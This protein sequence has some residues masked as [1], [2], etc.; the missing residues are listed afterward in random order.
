MAP[1]SAVAAPARAR[2]SGDSEAVPPPV[3]SRLGESAWPRRAGARPC[4]TPGLET[5][6]GA[7]TPL[8]R[9]FCPPAPL[10]ALAGAGQ[11]GSVP[12]GRILGAAQRAQP[13]PSRRAAA[14]GSILLGCSGAQI[15]APCPGL[16]QEPQM[17][18]GL[19]KGQGRGRGRRLRGCSAGWK[20]KGGGGGCVL[21]R[22]TVLW[23]QLPWKLRCCPRC[24]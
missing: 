6:H 9:D 17:G 7:L 11:A 22:R 20:G 18:P 24:C 16:N 13:L 3:A 19:G 23:I 2:G 4:S 21:P 12:A 8:Q 5:Q 15:T 10:P 14:P 1:G